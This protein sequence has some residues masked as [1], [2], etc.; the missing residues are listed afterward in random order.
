MTPADGWLDAYDRYRERERD[1]YRWATR[2][3]L[4]DLS[5]ADLGLYLTRARRAVLMADDDNLPHVWRLQVQ[6]EL[7]WAEAE[8]DW[9]LRA[10]RKSGPAVLR[11]TFRERLRALVE[12]QDL[13]TLVERH[14]LLQRA[15]HEYRGLCPFHAEKTPS[16]FVNAETQL[17]YCHGCHEGGDLIKWVMDAEQLDF[18]G[19]VR[20]LEQHSFPSVNGRAS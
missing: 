20:F 15:G 12:R 4:R 19:A 11:G 13:L 8:W 3:E 18:M 16:F 17:W 10:E 14:V 9:R 1:A 6:D 7:A 5:D 2:A